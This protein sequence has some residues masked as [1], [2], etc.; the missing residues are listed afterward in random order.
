MKTCQETF[1]KN[2]L[3]KNTI[4]DYWQKVKKHTGQ[5]LKYFLTTYNCFLVFQ[6]RYQCMFIFFQQP[7]LVRLFLKFLKQ[8][9]KRMWCCVMII[10][11]RNFLE[12]V[13]VTLTI[14]VSR[15]ACVKNKKLSLTNIIIITKEFLPTFTKHPQLAGRSPRNEK[16]VKKYLGIV[17]I[18]LITSSTLFLHLSSLVK[19]LL[20]Q[21][22]SSFS[23]SFYLT[24]TAWTLI[25]LSYSQT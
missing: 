16:R 24:K 3:K 10:Y 6:F 19:I 18:L 8:K 21:K 25:N 17:N 4:I 12:L 9:T 1:Q 20:H 23:R 15:K 11:Y 5:M 13:W 22:T 7:H 2:Q 14:Q